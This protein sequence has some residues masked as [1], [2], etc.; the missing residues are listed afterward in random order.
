MI[1][2]STLEICGDLINQSSATITGTNPNA[3]V[4]FVGTGNTIYRNAGT[5]NFDK[6]SMN[7]TNTVNTLTIE[8]DLTTADLIL[9]RGKILTQ[10]GN[11]KVTVT[12]P[13]P[14][15]IT[16]AMPTDNP[17]YVV[18]PHKSGHESQ[19]YKYPL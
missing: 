11:E 5:T 6:I 18:G 14:D 10:T 9:L 8:S 13:A 4:S 12:R 2:N 3:V 17:S 19:L 16:L 1:A 7:K 15:A